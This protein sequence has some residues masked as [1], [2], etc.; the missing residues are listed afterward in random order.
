MQRLRRADE[1]TRS[2]WPVFASLVSDLTRLTFLADP[3]QIVAQR[4]SREQFYHIYRLVFPK[5]R[6][7]Y[8]LEVMDKYALAKGFMKDQGR[9]DDSK[10]ARI[11]LKVRFSHG[12]T[13]FPG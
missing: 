12:L 10:A 4:I 3:E 1:G 5:W 13:W 6:P 7:I 8:Y 2:I 9:P 11:I